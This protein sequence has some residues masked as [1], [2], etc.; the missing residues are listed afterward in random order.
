M[1]SNVMNDVWSMKDDHFCGV[2]LLWDDLNSHLNVRLL[3]YILGYIR[4]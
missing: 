1:M 3:K 2:L 4:H